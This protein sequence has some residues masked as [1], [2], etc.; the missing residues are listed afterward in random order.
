[1]LATLGRTTAALEILIYLYIYGPTSKTR[2]AA[3]LP[4]NHETVARAIRVLRGIGLVESEKS[5]TFPFRDTCSL[6]SHG[7]Q[8]VE[9]PAHRWPALFLDWTGEGFLRS[10]RSYRGGA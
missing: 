9:A 7:R 3:V 5:R 10:S 6:T 8:L 4:H 1:M 2:L